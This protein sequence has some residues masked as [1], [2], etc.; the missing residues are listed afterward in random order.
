MAYYNIEKRPKSD[1][2]PRYHCNMIIK[3]NGVITY[4]E[5]KILPKHAHAKTWGM[6]KVM[7]L[8]LYG[9][10]SSND[11]NGLTVRR[12]YLNDPNAGGQAGRTKRY[13]LELLNDVLN[14][15]G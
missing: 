6:Q 7:E 4:R 15:V 11:V 9:I 10:P 3:E 14:I 8:D 12:K 5:N 2:A 13:L 1:G